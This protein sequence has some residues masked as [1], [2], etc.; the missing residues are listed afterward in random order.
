MAA[1]N[2]FLVCSLALAY[3][4]RPVADS[5]VCRSAG[6]GLQALVADNLVVPV[7]KPLLFAVGL[8]GS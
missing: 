8:A 6:K 2:S 4:I 5:L 3:Y 7:H 1:D